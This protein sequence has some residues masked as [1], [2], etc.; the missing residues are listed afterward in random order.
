MTDTIWQMYKHSGT[1][2]CQNDCFYEDTVLSPRYRQFLQERG[3]AQWERQEKKTLPALSS[4][5]YFPKQQLVSHFKVLELL[6]RRWVSKII[7]MFTSGDYLGI[8]YDIVL[9][10]AGHK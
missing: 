4:M 9:Q 1:A 10:F 5:V 2:I 6:C 8:I 3:L 7:K